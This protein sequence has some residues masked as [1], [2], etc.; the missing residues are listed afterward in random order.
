MLILL[1]A[2]LLDDPG[3][4]PPAVTIRLVHPGEQG[5]RLLKL[6][7][8]ARAPNPAAALAGYKR[9]RGGDTGLDKPLDAAIS[10]LN[11][12][13]IAELRTLD[14]ATLALGWAAG[15]RA[16]WNAAVPHD[17]GTFAAFATAGVL[18]DGASDPPLD[19]LPVDRLGPRPTATVAARAPGGF[20]LA[21]SRDEL[22]AAL[23]RSTGPLPRA[24]IDG[25]YLVHVDPKGLAREGAPL[26]ARRAGVA[27]ARLGAE[28]LDASIRLEGEALLVDARVR[29]AAPPA[30]AKATIPPAW[31]DEIP[32]EGTIAAFAIAL[33]PSPAAWNAA[34]DLL[35]AVDR[36]DP[37][38][39]NLA[40]L[41][42]RLNLL[43][44]AAVIKPDIDLWPRLLGVSAIVTAGSAG[45]VDGVL[46]RLHARDEPSARRL[47]TLTLP[48]IAL[49][50][51]GLK[52]D[53]GAE[54]VVPMVRGKPITFSRKGRD[55][56]VAW[57]DLV[58][59][60]A[61][62]AADAPDRRL[63]AEV[64]AGAQR[65]AAFW[66]GRLKALGLPDAPP[67]VWVGSFDGATSL[68]TIRWPGLKAVVGRV[69]ERIPFDP[70]PDR[71]TPPSS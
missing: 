4:A 2:L 33:D 46:L 5:E 9:A 38:R 39:A 10:A 18:T 71:A 45:P 31:L 1:A 56:A 35:D 25:G 27:L 60:R 34:F 7:E 54:P 13:M 50:A 19:G 41:R 30:F 40:P 47:E 3:P 48:R 59:A 22:A 17:D 29:Y 6:F 51:L 70:P 55:V 37:A 52:D 24:P 12:G 16:A 43:G 68:D 67:A 21:S 14:D 65:F 44:S 62:L 36:A 57:G 63:H 11:P 28:G 23:R 61:E 66:P 32:A 26:G 69:L 64:G 20:L 42:L 53:P 15:G 58:R 8:G 49:A